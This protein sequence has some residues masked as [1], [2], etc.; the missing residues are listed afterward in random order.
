MLFRV[1]EAEDGGNVGQ[2]SGGAWGFEFEQQKY[3]Q[4]KK[5]CVAAKRTY[6]E[7]DVEQHAEVTAVKTPAKNKPHMQSA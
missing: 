6:P 2:Q 3:Q 5:Q 7:N 1:P 4:D